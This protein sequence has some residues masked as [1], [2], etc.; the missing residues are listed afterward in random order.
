MCRAADVAM[1]MVNRSIELADKTKNT[2]YYM[3]LV[4][5]HNLLYLAQCDMLV[6]YGRPMF[7]EQITAHQ[8]GPYVEGLLLPSWA[9]SSPPTAG[10]RR[11]TRCWRSSA[12]GA[13][14]SW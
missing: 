14:R 5:L 3:D 12:P 4:K 10:W 1:T 7:V 6:N 2:G 8:C 11:S 13:R 9:L